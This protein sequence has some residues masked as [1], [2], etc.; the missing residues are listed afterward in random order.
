[1]EEQNVVD[2]LLSTKP[3]IIFFTGLDISNNLNINTIVNE[4][5]KIFSDYCI[6]LDFM[7]LDL[8]DSGN[9]INERIQ[10][11]KKM[12]NKIILVKSKSIVISTKPDIHINLSISNK[13]AKDNDITDEY[14]S[15]YLKILEKNHIN[16]YFNIKKDFDYDEFIN[17][18][19]DYIIE[20]IEKKVYGD[21]YEKYSHK[22]FEN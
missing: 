21:K 6:V 4:L 18:I 19:F 10:E 11:V 5:D 2:V 8:E 22:Y 1:M 14:Y 12:D 20:D 9:V 3:Y 13:M 7:H 16:K 17:K 15:N